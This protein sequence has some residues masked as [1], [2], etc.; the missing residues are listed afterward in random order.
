MAAR[1]P[2]RRVALTLRLSFHVPVRGPRRPVPPDRLVTHCRPQ[3]QQVACP[4]PVT[5]SDSLP[6]RTGG[7]AL[8]GGK[9][10]PE[11]R[12][13]KRALYILAVVVVVAV[14][15]LTAFTIP[16]AAQ[17]QT[18]YV[19]LPSGQVVPVTVDVPPGTPLKDI[20]L[21]G[22]PVGTATTPTKPSTTPTTPPTT[23]TTTAPAPK[24][25]GAGGGHPQKQGGSHKPSHKPA[26]K[27]RSQRKKKEKKEK[28]AK[29]HSHKKRS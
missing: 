20:P 21:P 2:R 28:K 3:G 25:P 14:A 29:R 15:G 1:P 8:S 23:G 10:R 16:A 19:K 6:A 18:I 11:S 22:V 7:L 12:M 26:P 17:L 24:P 4:D 27:H 9:T 5:G 13:T